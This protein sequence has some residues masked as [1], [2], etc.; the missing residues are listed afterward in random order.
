MSG[1][2]DYYTHLTGNY[3]D[4]FMIGYDLMENDRP[5]NI[6]R[7]N[8]TYSTHLFANKVND[9]IQKQES[10]KVW[11]RNQNSSDAQPLPRQTYIKMFYKFMS[12]RFDK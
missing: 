6:S 5:A 10:S 12:M 9:L 7:Y 3:K 4:T 8:G 1:H 11:L 2:S